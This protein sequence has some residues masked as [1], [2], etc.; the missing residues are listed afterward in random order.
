MG[1]T[2]NQEEL[3][4]RFLEQVNARQEETEGHLTTLMDSRIPHSI[5]QQVEE[6]TNRFYEIL[7]G[8]TPTPR[9]GDKAHSNGHGAPTVGCTEHT[10]YGENFSP[11]KGTVPRYTK[12]DFPVFNGVDNPLTWLYRC[13]FFF[14]NQCTTDIDKVGLAAFHMLDEAQLWGHQ[15]E[16]E[17]LAQYQKKFQEKLSR[18][19]K[20]VRV[21]QQV[22]LFTAGLIESLRLE[23]ELLGPTDLSC[24]MNWVRALEAKQRFQSLRPVWPRAKSSSQVPI[25]AQPWRTNTASQPN[26]GAAAPTLTTPKSDP[27]TPTFICKL[28]RSEM[29]AHRAKG[30]EVEEP[31]ISLHAITGLQSTTTMQLPIQPRP[32]ASVSVANGEKV[33]SYG[34]TKAV[35]F[36]SE[37]HHFSAECFIIPLACFDM[38]LGVKWLQTLGP[39]LWDFAALTMSFTIDH[40]KVTLQGRTDCSIPLLHYDHR[41]SLKAG[42]EVVVVRPYRYP[43]IQKDE[44]ERQCHHMLQQGLIRPNKLPIPVVDELLDE[45]NGATFFTKLD[46]RWGYHQVRMFPLD[47][48]KTAFCT[49]HGHFEFIGMPFSLSNA[50]STFQAL[51]N[52]VFHDYLRKFVLV[53]FDDILIYSKSCTHHLRDLQLVFQLLRTHHLYLKCSKCS[54][55]THIERISGLSRVLRKIHPQLC[56][57]AAPLSNLFRR[58]AFHWNDSTENSFQTLKQALASALVLQ[59]PDFEEV[60]VVEYDASS[61]GIGAVLQQNQHPIA[62]FRHQLALH[63]HKLPPYKRELIGLAKAVR[64]WRPYLWGHFSIIHTDHYSLKFL[65]DQRISTSPQQHWLSKLMGF[66]F[67]VGHKAVTLNKA[68]DALSRCIEHQLQLAAISHPTPLLLDSIWEANQYNPQLQALSQ[69]I[70][71]STKSVQWGVQDHLILYKQC[72]YLPSTSPLIV[73]AVSSYHDSTHEGL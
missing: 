15:L 67:Q 72:I 41:I 66:D 60:F 70:A 42:S 30:Q 55:G 73:V 39:I 11:D 40:H 52:E 10:G 19:S 2:S 63:H 51:M 23:V 37:N 17:H 36:V 25:P 44:I 13:E 9:E 5:A 16:L 50:P 12:L 59:V 38:V 71:A 54:F 22:S 68:T 47:I 57:L 62:Y 32:V 28:N 43:H 58:N 56:T 64:H 18:A 34:V 20:V 4:A 14:Y 29:E 3:L 27:S 48:K 26:Q 33:P 1:E 21:D 49:H 24:A 65:L 53:F 31:A 8:R 6:I 46:L 61:G 7:S 69:Q 35:V 45:L